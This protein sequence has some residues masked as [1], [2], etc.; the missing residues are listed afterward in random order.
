MSE[1]RAPLFHRELKAFAAWFFAIYHDIRVQGAEHVPAAGPAIIAANHPT[2]LDP[3]F[4]MVGIARPVRFMA[5]ERPF[6]VPLLGTLLRAYGAIPVD[7]KRPG[8]ASFEAAVRVLR[9]GE[10]FGIFPE[11]GRTKGG[12]QMNP[13]KSGVARLALMTGAP[14]V[15]ATIL[16]GRRVWRRG[17]R[18]PKPGPIEVVF[19]P[20]IRVAPE[21][22]LSWRRDRTLEGRLIERLIATINQS[23]LPSL[24][25]EER[26]GRLLEAGPRPAGF[27]DLT[28][29]LFATASLAAVPWELW[30]RRCGPL[31]AA[32]AAWTLLLA[33]EL[34][35]RPAGAWARAARNVGPWAALAAG[36]HGAA[37]PPSAPLLA[38]EAAAAAALAWLMILRFPLYRRLSAPLLTLAHGLWLAWVRGN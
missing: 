24:R 29:A 35:V 17:E 23:L 9:A 5:W 33:L 30:T 10:V 3:A 21:E 37:G 4:L 8:R 7:M 6:R 38:A 15:P 18:L 2:Y 36:F 22:R 32:A 1:D 16:G 20:P 28:P 11:G 25:R 14:I 13:F 12:D 19:H 26:V 27:A 31:A 34:A